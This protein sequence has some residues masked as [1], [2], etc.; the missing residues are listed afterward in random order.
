MDKGKMRSRIRVLEMELAQRQLETTVMRDVSELIGSG[1]PLQKIYTRVASLIREILDAETVLIPVINDNQ[2]TY[3]YMS[4][5]G[6]HANELTG[7]TLPTTVG[8]CGWVMENQTAWWRGM[9]DDLE[10]SSRPVVDQE[11]TVIIVPMVGKRKMLGGIACMNKIGKVEF[12]R[13]DF[14]LLTLFASQASFAI[15][16]ALF[17]EDLNKANES[18]RSMRRRLEKSNDRL[19]KA[20]NDL[21]YMAHYDALTGLPNRALIIERLEHCLKVAKREQSHFALL[22]IDLD[23][24][25][26]INDTLGHET[27]DRLLVSISLRFS[28]AVREVDMLGRL[29]G[30]EFAVVIKDADE[31][32]ASLIAMRLQAALSSPV[33]IDGHH[34]AIAAS[35]GIAMH[36]GNASTP[37]ALMKLADIAMYNAKQNHAEY[38]FYCKSF[39]RH[40]PDKLALLS[41]LSKAI[42]DNAFDVFFQPKLDYRTGE[43][44]GFEALARWIHPEKGFIPPDV[45]I[46]LIES[47]HQ[48]KPFTLQILG[49]SLKECLRLRSLG[50]RFDVAV[51]L[52]AHNMLDPLL[53]EQVAELMGRYR[54]KRHM[55]TLEITE[56]AIMTDTENAMRVL[57]EFEHMGIQLSID[58]FGTG[59]SSLGYLQR[60]PV[61]QLKIDRTF[62]GDMMQNEN[63]SAIVKSTID[64]AHNLGLNTVAEGIEDVGTL[65]KLKAMGCDSAQGYYISRPLPADKILDFLKS[66]PW[67]A[68]RLPEKISASA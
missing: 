48:I 60:L 20:N 63:N 31:K 25:K 41:E 49:K 53:T 39:D 61:H 40:D 22:I 65:N 9:Q 4:A 12:S 11:G 17:V 42:D 27:G 58:D 34:F 38:T 13:R 6:V 7:E 52:S 1:Y 44:T 28:Q 37:Q 54:V 55:L 43:I 15:D 2:K 10:D 8:V 29:G 36:P 19:K 35:M 18:E 56:S 68:R 30:D 3:T 32:K 51:N 50:Y 46:P 66:C 47:T 67:P 16:N 45:F 33:C 24:F 62:V 64:L 23:R 21:T 59:Y 57:S 26:D 14:E 5:S